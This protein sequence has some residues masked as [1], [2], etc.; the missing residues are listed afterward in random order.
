MTPEEIIKLVNKYKVTHC[1][2]VSNENITEEDI[3]GKCT[4]VGMAAETAEE[5]VA[6]TPVETTK[7]T[8]SKSKKKTTETEN[9]VV[10]SDIPAVETETTVETPETETKE[11]E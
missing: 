7:T 4:L 11:N 10:E 5:T 9:I 1:G 6:E 3:K 2:L 8:K